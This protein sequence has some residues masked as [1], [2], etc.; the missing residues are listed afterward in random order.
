[1]NREQIARILASLDDRD[2]DS[3]ELKTVRF[4]QSNSQSVY[5]ARADRILTLLP[6]KPKLELIKF[7][8]HNYESPMDY[9]MGTDAQLE[10]D[11]AVID[12]W[13]AGMKGEDDGK[14]V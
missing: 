9:S 10:A 6:E 3:L 8:H 14:T 4:M 11:T 7:D 5:L 2:W 1:M 12:R 13:W